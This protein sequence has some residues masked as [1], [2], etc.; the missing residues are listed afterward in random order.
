MRERDKK[1]LYLFF[2]NRKK[3]VRERGAISSKALDFFFF[4]LSPLFFP[5]L[6]PL[7]FREGDSCAALSISI[8]ALRVA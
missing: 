3:R 6:A 1:K 2:R 7:S 4:A 5:S 8:A